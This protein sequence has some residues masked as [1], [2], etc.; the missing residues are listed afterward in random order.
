LINDEVLVSVRFSRNH[1][2]L[3]DWNVLLQNG[4]TYSLTILEQLFARGI[5]FLYGMLFHQVFSLRVRFESPWEHPPATTVV[6]D[7]EN[8][9]QS[10]DN[11]EKCMVS[12]FLMESNDDGDL[13]SPSDCHIFAI[14]SSNFF[15][16]TKFDDYAWWKRE[17]AGSG[18]WRN[19]SNSF[20]PLYDAHQKDPPDFDKDNIWWKNLDLISRARSGLIAPLYDSSEEE[21]S[22]I[23]TSSSLLLI[24]K[25]WIEYKRHLETWKLGR[26]P[27]RISKLQECFY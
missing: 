2:N 13:I 3:S 24:I 25:E 16:A 18:T 19:C 15:N 22:R 9:Q 4:A 7:L 21:G 1:Y 11:L 26:E 10:V 5:K 17:R 12:M 23:Q 14:P 6:L 8:V 27:F 20:L